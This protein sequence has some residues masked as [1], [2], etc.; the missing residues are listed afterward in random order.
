MSTCIVLVKFMPQAEHK[1]SK[2]SI[3]SKRIRLCPQA[4]LVVNSREVRLGLHAALLGEDEDEVGH[5]REYRDG[6]ASGYR[7]R[8]SFVVMSSV[9]CPIWDV[10]WLRADSEG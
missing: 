7:H 8:G 10:S 3:R 5:E 4:Q 9:A 6:E 1:A 2:S